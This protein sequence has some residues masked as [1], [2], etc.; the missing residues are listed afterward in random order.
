M[1]AKEQPTGPAPADAL[2]AGL[3]AGVSLPPPPDSSPARAPAPPITEPS[4]EPDPGPRGWRKFFAIVGIVAA[5]PFL[6]TIPGWIAL[7]AYRKWKSGER[8][9]PTWLIIWGVIASLLFLVA[10]VVGLTDP[11]GSTRSAVTAQPS[12]ASVTSSPEKNTMVPEV[13]ET[14][15]GRVVGERL[16]LQVRSLGVVSDCSEGQFRRL[17]FRTAYIFSCSDVAGSQYDPYLFYL[18]LRNRTQRAVGVSLA[19]IVLTTRNGDSQ[20]PV[21]VRRDADKPEAFLAA[22]ALIP[23]RGSVRGWVAF[24]GQIGFVPDRLVYIDA[25]QSLTIEF[26]GGYRIH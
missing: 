24:D 13:K 25:G 22:H 1:E 16:T 5:F 6:L 17:G 8:A 18:E 21:N 23:P 26:A 14:F 10:F 15:P 9:Q 20:G 19:R 7:S 3:E 4:S 11:N 12:T 2:A